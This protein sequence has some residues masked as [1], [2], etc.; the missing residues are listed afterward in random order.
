MPL[1]IFSRWPSVWDA[2]YAQLV[3][4]TQP[5][6]RLVGVKGVTRTQYPS[7]ANQSPYVGVQ[8][9]KSRWDIIGQRRRRENATFAVVIFSIANGSDA[10]A[11]PIES[12]L[13]ALRPLVNDGNGNGLEAILN[14]AGSFLAPFSVRSEITDLEYDILPTPDQQAQAI[15]YA[16]FLLEVSDQVSSNG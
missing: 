8:F 4:E 10:L 9:T 16:R 5:G 3:T 12:A 2:I 1:P 15:A 13:S 11:D 14:G 7:T 6:G